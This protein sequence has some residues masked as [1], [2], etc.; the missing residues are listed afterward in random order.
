M[1]SRKQ[2]IL[3]LLGLYVVLNEEDRAKYR[4]ILK[5]MFPEQFKEMEQIMQAINLLCR[6]TTFS[7][8]LHVYLTKDTIKALVK[9]QVELGICESE[10]IDWDNDPIG[11]FAG[12]PVHEEIYNAVVIVDVNNEEILAKIRLSD[13]L[14]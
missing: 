3:T 10:E 1:T 14:I 6:K 5:I 11:Y 7:T 8:N 9:R 12:Y 13:N 2:T 4:K